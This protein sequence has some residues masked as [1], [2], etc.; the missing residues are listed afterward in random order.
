MPVITVIDRKIREKITA[1]VMISS[2]KLLTT[3]NATYK[4]M[5][6][7]TTPSPHVAYVSARMRCAAASPGG[8][9]STPESGSTISR[10]CRSPGQ[11]SKQQEQH[12]ERQRRPQPVGQ[13]AVARQVA[14]ED[15]LGD[16]EQDPAQE[17]ERDAR[18]AAEGGGG[19][20]RDQ[21]DE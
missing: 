21:Q 15:P 20:R 17:R 14:A 13:D 16:A 3:N 6:I 18:E 5:A 10:R 1:F 11:N 8:G 7:T 4:P 19:D 2:Q 12:H 9:G